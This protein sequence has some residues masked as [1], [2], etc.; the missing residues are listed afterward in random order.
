MGGMNEILETGGLT[1]RLYSLPVVG[2]LVYF[3]LAP[4]PVNPLGIVTNPSWLVFCRSSG[5]LLLYTLYVYTLQRISKPLWQNP[6]F[7]G[8]FA[9]FVGIIVLAAVG[10]YEF[11]HKVPSLP[12]LAVMASVAS[13]AGERRLARANKQGFGGQRELHYGPA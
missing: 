10:A 13:A 6:W 2:P 12:F 7:V 11:R 8:A 4:L 3:V 5:S 1:S 9:Y